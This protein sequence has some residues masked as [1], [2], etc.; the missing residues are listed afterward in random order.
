MTTPKRTEA[1]SGPMRAELSAYRSAVHASYAADASALARQRERLA[2]RTPWERHM[3]YEKL[4]S[5][6]SW[7]RCVEHLMRWVNA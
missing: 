1:G 7:A 2:L 4:G 5:H 6:I 3:A